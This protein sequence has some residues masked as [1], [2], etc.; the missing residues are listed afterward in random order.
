MI[1]VMVLNVLKIAGCLGPS[2]YVTV[3]SG[4]SSNGDRKFSNFLVTVLVT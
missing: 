3:G 1:E 2:F 4:G